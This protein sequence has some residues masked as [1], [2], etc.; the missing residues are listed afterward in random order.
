VANDPV[1]AAGA[2]VSTAGVGAA[3]ALFAFAAGLFSFEATFVFDAAPQ[4]D[5]ADASVMVTTQVKS[6]TSI[7]SNLSD[8]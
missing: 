2:V 6:F 5:N 1:V 8:G 4:P 7:S 3:S